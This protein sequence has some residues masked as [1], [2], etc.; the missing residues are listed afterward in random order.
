MNASEE[1][2]ESLAE[3]PP[4]RGRWTICAMLFVATTINYVDRQVLSILKPILHGQTIQ[5]QPLF[6]GW[7]SFETTINVT[8][9]EYGYILAAF[10]VAY[11]LG[12]I[13]AGRFVDRVGCRKGYPI[14]TG[15][16]SLAAMAHALVRTVMGFGIARFFLGLG[17]SGNFP[18]A[19]KA[20]AEWFPPKERSLATGIFNSGAGVGAILAPLAVPWVALHFGW[21]AAFLITGIFSAI[22]IVW[23]SIRYRRPHETMDQSRG[24]IV[25]APPASV[26]PWW[27]LLKHRQAWA[28]MV[29]KFLTDPVWWFFLF[30]LP[31]YFH[32]RFALDLTHIGPP[33]VT[34]YVVSTIGSVYGGWLPRGY[35]RVGMQLKRARLAAMLTCACCVLPVLTAGSLSSEWIAVALLSLAAAAHQGW[36]AN[37]FTTASDMFPSEHVGTVVSFGQ[38]AGALGGAIFQPIA[39]NI[40]QLTHSYVPLFLYSGCAY[41]VALLLLRTLAPGLK[42]AQLGTSGL[43]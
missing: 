37:I 28:F 25:I 3:P 21:R 38:V 9:R 43:S 35:M 17:E 12:V 30:W 16:W 19:I 4:L 31:Q 29:G 42:R 22:W 6:P 15:L 5:L 26:V 36:S 7:P 24:H 14:V 13:F 27:S 23:W 39:G 1:P 20:T 41:L 2:I 10:Q 32:S 33:L 8:D 40:L 18:A 11:A 34:V